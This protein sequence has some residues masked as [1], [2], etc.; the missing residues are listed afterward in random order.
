MF[1]C[2]FGAQ[3]PVPVCLED[4][5]YVRVEG[6]KLPEKSFLVKNAVLDLVPD[7]TCDDTGEGQQSDSITLTGT[8]EGREEVFEES[9]IIADLAAVVDVENETRSLIY[10]IKQWRN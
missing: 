4:G 10:R 9:Q 8:G 6:C 3:V 5:A 2:R 1:N 7:L